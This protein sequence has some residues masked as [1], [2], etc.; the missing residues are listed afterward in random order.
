VQLPNRVSDRWKSLCAG[1]DEQQPF[2]ARFHFALPAV[3]RFNPRD[4]IYS[5]SE[6][7][8]DQM[9]G[10]FAGFVFGPSGG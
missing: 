10:E 3:D 8:L 4:D 6:L 2:L 7:V 9:A 1:F 5:G